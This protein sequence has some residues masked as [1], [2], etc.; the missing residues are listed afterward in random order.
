M[1]GGA[2]GGGG[3]GVVSAVRQK[4]QTLRSQLLA[5]ADFFSV[6]DG[7]FVSDRLLNLQLL[8]KCL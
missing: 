6:H 4:V 3:G 7:A 1:T 2:G 8:G 5:L